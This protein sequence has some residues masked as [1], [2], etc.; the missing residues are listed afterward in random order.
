MYEIYQKH[1]SSD[2]RGVKRV[3]VRLALR[4]V[5]DW[6]GGR[7]RVGGRGEVEWAGGWSGW[8]GRRG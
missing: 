2:R 7:G 3:K 4:G 5:A 1:N 6:A 8:S